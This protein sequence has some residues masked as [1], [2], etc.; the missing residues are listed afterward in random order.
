MA[1]ITFD[2]MLETGVLVDP[3]PLWEG[4]LKRPE[5]LS[6]PGLI[7]NLRQEGLGS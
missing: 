7:E 2:M 5:R 4:D 6:N 3:L 1:G